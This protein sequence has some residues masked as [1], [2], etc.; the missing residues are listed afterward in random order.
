MAVAFRGF[1]MRHWCFV[2]SESGQRN[3]AKVENMRSVFW[4]NAAQFWVLA[5]VLKL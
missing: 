5:K 1:G 3:F 2:D 4:C